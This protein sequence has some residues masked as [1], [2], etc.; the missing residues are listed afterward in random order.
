MNGKAFRLRPLGDTIEVA[1]TT[2][3]AIVVLRGNGL[4]RIEVQD[5]EDEPSRE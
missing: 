4:V 2:H 3:D 5:L 1:F